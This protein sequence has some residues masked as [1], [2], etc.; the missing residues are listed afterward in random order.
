MSDVG[1]VRKCEKVYWPNKAICPQVQGREWE[2][3]ERTKYKVRRTKRNGVADCGPP[4]AD[5]RCASRLRIEVSQLGA[6]TTGRDL[7]IT[8]HESRTT[9]KLS[10]RTKPFRPSPKAS[11]GK[12]LGGRAQARETDTQGTG[13]SQIGCNGMRSDQA[14]HAARLGFAVQTEADYNGL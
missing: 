14:S 3:D 12:V 6:P 4:P 13:L 7:R 8:D 1:R 2:G 10:G 11:K 5:L 9:Q